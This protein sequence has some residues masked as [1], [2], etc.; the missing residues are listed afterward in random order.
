M[1]A[2]HERVIET[3]DYEE[4]AHHS[5]KPSSHLRWSIGTT[6]DVSSRLHVD[7]GGLSTASVI[8]NNEGV[9]WWA[10]GREKNP[11]RRAD[12]LLAFEKFDPSKAGEFEWDAV[13]L[14][15]GDVLY[16]ALLNPTLLL[17]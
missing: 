4:N 2:T 13:L 9:K 12:S 7:T 16:V 1:L 15:R 6:P 8:L 10:L 11:R 3:I 14:K 5:A 17:Y